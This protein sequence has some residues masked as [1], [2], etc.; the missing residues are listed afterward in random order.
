METKN[1]NDRPSDQPDR[2]RRKFIKTVGAGA[3]S[4][5]LSSYMQWA[6]QTVAFVIAKDDTIAQSGPV[7]WAINELGSTLTSLGVTVRR[8]NTIDEVTSGDLCL[9]IGG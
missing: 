9:I 1:S 8:Y 7:Q 4:L 6:E 5:P 2:S 3:L